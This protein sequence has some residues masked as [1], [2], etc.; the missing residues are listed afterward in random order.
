MAPAPPRR[1]VVASPGLSLVEILVG[2]AIGL[3]GIVA[4][5][6]AVAVW[7]KHTSTTSSG[8]DAQVAGTLALFNIERDLK[9]AGHGFAQ[10]GDA[11]AWAATLPSTTTRRR[12]TSTSACAPSTSR[13]ARAARPTRS[14]SCYGDSSF[15]VAR[16]QLHRF[17]ARRPR[18]CAAA[19]AF[20][21]GDLAVVAVNAGRVGGERGLPAHRDHQ[22]RR[23]RR[24]H[25]RTYRGC[26]PKLLQPPAGAAG[27]AALQRR[28]GA[29]RH[30]GDDVQPRPEAATRHVGHPGQPHV[31]TRTDLIQRRA[32]MQ[33]ADGVVNLKAE[34]GIDSDGDGRSR[35]PNGRLVPRAGRLAPVLRRPR[36]RPGA[37]PAVRAQRR[38]GRERRPRRHADAA[39]SRSTSVTR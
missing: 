20:K 2:V 26:L 23:S 21:P 31:L 29:G 8:G 3:I 27:R 39:Q 25:R 9:Q 30:V 37:Q 38:S 16:R 10:G 28:R 24:V 19:P 35:R 12:A 14:R 34:Y 11:G 18:S 5:F 6:Q 22:G 36:R 13:P 33:I 1:R 4:I 7:T 17:D 32:P 15:F